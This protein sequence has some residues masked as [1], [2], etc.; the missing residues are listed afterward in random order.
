MKQ[1]LQEVITLRSTNGLIVNGAKRCNGSVAIVIKKDGFCVNGTNLKTDS[2]Y[3]SPL[4]SEKHRK[5]I[6][7]IVTQWMSENQQFCKNNFAKLEQFY[8]KFVCKKGFRDYNPLYEKMRVCCNLFLENILQDIEHP[9][10]SLSSLTEQINSFICDKVKLLFTDEIV[11]QG[12]TKNSKKQI[13]K[14]KEARNAFFVDVLQ[15]ITSQL[16]VDFLF[17][18]PH[19]FLKQLLSEETGVLSVNGHNYLGTFIVLRH[20]KKLLLVNSVDIDDYLVSVI[21]SEGWPGWPLEVNKVQAITSRTYLVSKVLESTKAKRPYHIVN[22]IKHQTYKGHHKY[23]RL[24]QAIDE[25][26]DIFI[27]Y[28]GKP[29]VAMFDA[30]CG[31]VI[32]AKSEEIDFKKFPYLAR[33]KSCTYCKKCWIY[34]WNKEFTRTQLAETL[35]KV[36]P[37]I[38]V[39]KDIKVIEKDEAGLVHR[40]L[41]T[42]ARG[43]Y[44]VS[45]KK[46]YSLFSAIKSFS[47]L[48]KRKG[49]NFTIVGR[50]YGHHVGLCQWGAWKMVQDHWNYE[51]IL[52]FYYPGT[53]LMRLSYQR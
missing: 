38:R 5:K 28:D 15:K 35:Q 22:T 53:Q 33:K 10:I 16:F 12:I 9:V 19:K 1:A 40:V 6:R 36:I 4:L 39:L 32:P 37:D 41:V 21:R 52:Q 44:Y 51:K 13:V 30:C 20:S 8:T 45:G 43:K 26:R 49:K 24:K 18:L 31:G 23:V 48:I 3:I 17:Q 14:L 11:K 50:G 42:T 27:A 29:I 46:M 34:R 7:H 2:L 47:Y 25:T